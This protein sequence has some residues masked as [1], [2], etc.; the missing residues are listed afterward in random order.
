[1]I[2]VDA[3]L[4]AEARGDIPAEHSHLIGVSIAPSGRYA[5]VM[6]TVGEGPA[7]EFD[8]TVA[9]RVGDR[10]SGLFSGTP[11]STI[12]AFGDHRGAPLCNYM[13]PLPPD[14]NRVIVHD[15]GEEH[16]VPV[17]N[18]YYLYVA[19]KQDT[20]GDDTTDPPSPSFV[21]ALVGAD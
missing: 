5:V 14:V 11:S 12:Y 17:E 3:Q 21:H 9:E 2:P 16:T 7:M 1:M 19:W 8:Q 18:G 20:A 10:W 15:R 13:E 4:E 6:L